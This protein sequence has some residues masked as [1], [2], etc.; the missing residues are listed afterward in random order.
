MDLRKGYPHNFKFTAT[1]LNQDFDFYAFSDQDDIWLPHKLNKATR[2]L[3]ESH[4]ASELLSMPMLY[5][6][7]YEHRKL[8]QQIFAIFRHSTHT[9]F[10]P[11]SGEKFIWRKHYGFQPST[12]EIVCRFTGSAGPDF[13]YGPDSLSVGDRYRWV[14]TCDTTASINYRQHDDN[15]LGTRIS[16]KGRAYRLL[17]FLNLTYKREIDIN[18]DALM[19][20]AKH[21]APSTQ[22]SL[23]TIS[24]FSARWNNS[25][26]TVYVKC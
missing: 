4:N 17:K 15:K 5:R 25:T 3:I 11:F 10:C 23:K 19:T 13:S 26:A 22:V 18:I 8:Q 1:A 2:A 6:I 14:S 12:M 7:C 24:G 16:F 20:Q 21:F 9:Q